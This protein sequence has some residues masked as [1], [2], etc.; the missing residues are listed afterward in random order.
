[1][2][3]SKERKIEKKMGAKFFTLTFHVDFK[4]Y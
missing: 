4:Y 2:I 1:M 3:F